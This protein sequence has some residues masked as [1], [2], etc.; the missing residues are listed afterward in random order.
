MIFF[1]SLIYM[2][3]CVRVYVCVYV[4]GVCV[5]VCMYVCVCMCVCDNNLT[6]VCNAYDN[7]QLG[8]QCPD[9]SPTCIVF[10]A[11]THF[12]DINVSFVDIFFK[13]IACFL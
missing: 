4:Y 6:Y 7:G 10:F 2:C 3:V 8:T 1:F 11:D 5:C 9:I 13:Y 12:S